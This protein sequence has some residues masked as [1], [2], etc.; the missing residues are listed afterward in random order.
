MVY[1]CQMTIGGMRVRRGYLLI[2]L[3]VLL[4]LPAAAQAREIS[5]LYVWDGAVEMPADGS[6][7]AGAIQ[8]YKRG[9]TNRYL[10]LPS[11]VDA[12]SLRVHFTGADTFTVNGVT[13]ENNSVTDCFVPGETV[14]ITNGGST[15]HVIVR[16]SQNTASVYIK[17]QSGSIEWISESKR[18]HEPGSLYVLDETGAPAYGNDFEYI[19][20]RGNY[21]FYPYKK[22]FHIKLNDG[23]PMLCMP[24]AKTW[25]LLASYRDNAMIR[26]AL[27]F[28]LA[29]AAGMAY[30]P[31]YRFAEVYVNTT[32]Y[33]TYIFCEKI[34]I[35]KN[36]VA[37]FDLE[38]ATEQANEK[39]LSK[40]PRLGTNEYRRNTAKYYGVPNDPADITGGY[41]LQLELKDRYTAAASG[42]VTSH[43]Q[44]VLV[45]SPEYASKAQLQYIQA[46]VQSFENA[47]WAE[48]GIDPDSGL[49][50]SQIA[51]MSSLVG[52]YIVE[53]L[54]K[55]VDGNKSS[56]Y[57]YKYPDS[58]S[59]LLYFGPVW[60]YDI[61][62]GNYTASYYK[63]RN[64]PSGTGLMTAVDDYERFYWFPRLYAH[65]DFVE[66]VKEAWRDRFRPCLEVILG[67]REP[68][69]DTGH[70][71][72]LED[73]EAMLTAA[74]A[75]NFDRWRTFNDS[76]FPV[77]TGEDFHENI[78]FMRRFLTDRMNYLDSLWLD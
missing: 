43:G 42:F 1:L 4:A 3:L 35:Q 47:V 65:E 36:R 24:S 33:G 20:V 13:V 49:H 60:D 64:L 2:L 15:Y 39:D 40:Y 74:A 57:L 12:R 5:R 44:A 52:K 55:N 61:A 58:E 22:S 63:E 18:N 69:E 31:E 28:D 30:T 46:R 9:D 62:Y 37:V 72:S 41:L 70:L 25:L 59:T 11:G 10:Y 38:K 50:Y 21:S 7:P 73:Y 53:E 78:E 71:M 68:S 26:N 14:D 77:R 27:T 67:L 76:K 32:Y 45:K 48:D 17:T 8:W 75:M 6:L 51:D 54:T 16:Q 34:Q 56:F 29:S 23:S 19:R 66:A